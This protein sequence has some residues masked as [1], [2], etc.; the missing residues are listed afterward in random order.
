MSKKARRRQIME[1]VGY[2]DRR[3]SYHGNGFTY[4]RSGDLLKD[5][6]REVLKALDAWSPTYETQHKRAWRGHIR[7]AVEVDYDSQMGWERFDLHD[8]T[9]IWREVNTHD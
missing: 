7:D 2:P 6:L 4:K 5:E 9:V 8:L 3:V 1:A